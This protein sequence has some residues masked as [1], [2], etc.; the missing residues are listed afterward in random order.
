MF[1]KSPRANIPGARVGIRMI[2]RFAMALISEHSLDRLSL[3]SQKTKLLPGVAANTVK[4]NHSAM[5]ATKI[6]Q[7][8]KNAIILRSVFQRRRIYA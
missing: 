5:E 7:C 3:K 2:S 4:T 1:E 6:F 8:K